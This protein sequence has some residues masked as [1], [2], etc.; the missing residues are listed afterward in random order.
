[1]YG[2]S[3]ENPDSG[4]GCAMALGLVLLIISLITIG[5][6]TSGCGPGV[7]LS[8]GVYDVVGVQTV[9]TCNL[10][11]HDLIT[12]SWYID[13]VGDSYGLEHTKNDETISGSFDGEVI[14]LQ[15]TEHE[16]IDECTWSIV[17][18]VMLHPEGLQFIGYHRE[19]YY[20]CDGPFCEVE[21][22]IEGLK[23]TEY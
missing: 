19:D 21:W 10:V 14:L 15:K 16:E 3:N 4:A 23:R 9:D 2:E 18:T 8:A 5:T 7:P 17:T 1:M 20:D 6:C 12:P 22:D 13:Y 11:N